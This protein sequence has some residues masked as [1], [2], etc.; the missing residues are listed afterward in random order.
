MLERL[1]KWM[2][3]AIQKDDEFYGPSDLPE[4]LKHLQHFYEV[5]G[6]WPR[7]KCVA[8]NTIKFSVE[9]SQNI[10][11]SNK[12]SVVYCPGCLNGANWRVC[13]RTNDWG[14]ET[15]SFNIFESKKDAVKFAIENGY[16][17]DIHETE[18]YWR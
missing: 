10:Y 3:T 6:C 12:A 7:K 8:S 17:F 14:Q 2:H 16:D 13:G 1:K 11:D 4:H 5:F 9:E 18:K 15:W